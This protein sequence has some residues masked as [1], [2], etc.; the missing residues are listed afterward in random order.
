MAGRWIAPLN[1]DRM[2]RMA[3]EYAEYYVGMLRDYGGKSAECL[4]GSPRQ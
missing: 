4:A 3:L 1:D 2:R